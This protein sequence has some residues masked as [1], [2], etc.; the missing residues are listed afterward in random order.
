MEAALLPRR[1]ALAQENGAAICAAFCQFDEVRR[2]E[3]GVEA[4]CQLATDVVALRVKNRD[5]EAPADMIERYWAIIYAVSD[6][7]LPSARM[8]KVTTDMLVWMCLTRA[9][10][11]MKNLVRIH[12]RSRWEEVQEMIVA[13]QDAW[14]N[15]ARAK[16]AQARFSTLT[17]IVRGATEEHRAYMHSALI[18]ALSDVQA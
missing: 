16:Y 18:K 14:G 7:P 11:W 15:D 5:A 1:R 8:A 10:R 13:W 17:G 4:I 9:I 12:S 3:L 6:Q 2:L